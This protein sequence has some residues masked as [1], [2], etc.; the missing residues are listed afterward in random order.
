MPD[1]LLRDRSRSR[2]E[3]QPD[4]SDHLDR[5]I[6]QLQAE[7]E[8]LHNHLTALQRLAANRSTKR[9][10]KRFLAR[11]LFMRLQEYVQYAPRELSI[12]RSY[13]QPIP[14]VNP[15]AISIVT[16]TSNPGRFLEPTIQ[17]ILKQNYP[18]LDYVIEDG[19]S[20][21]GTR[22]TPQHHRHVPSESSADAGRADA[23]NRGFA[24]ADR[25]EIMAAITSDDLL[26]PGSLNYVAAFF[27]AH[28]EVD[29]VY[30]HRI[31][32]DGSGKEVGRWLLPPHSD[33]MLAWGNYIPP[34]T[35][36][37]RR[38]VWEKAGGRMNDAFRVA[39]D[40]ELLL[41]YRG[42]GAKFVR[43]PRF[44]G[45]FR[46]YSAQKRA[47]EQA[48]AG[49]TEMDRLRSE[50]HARATNIQEIRRNLKGYVIRHAWQSF[51]YQIG[52]G[53]E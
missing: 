17:S 5:E 40:W 21:D 42:L 30:G 20:R 26:L 39:F 51:L 34:E 18:R 37:W 44:L 19:G 31:I 16:P 25:G 11:C 13:W 50:L 22:D 6:A 52:F 12:P 24:H 36:F 46:L 10:V 43:V 28:P 41:R 47:I 48:I 8:E 53:P 49:P 33:R 1:S 23:I 14:L 2:R 45:A 35:L 15:P 4:S 9:C 32:I 3:S 7:V 38:R 29:V 27:A